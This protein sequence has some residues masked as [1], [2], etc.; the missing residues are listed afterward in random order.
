M[1]DNTLCLSLVRGL[2]LREVSA[3]I[4]C[5]DQIQIDMRTQCLAKADDFMSIS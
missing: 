1:K 4:R 2:Y 5:T 3:E